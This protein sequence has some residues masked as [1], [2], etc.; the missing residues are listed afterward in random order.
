MFWQ[1]PIKSSKSAVKLVAWP[2]T[3]SDVVLQH[4]KVDTTSPSSGD[5][6]T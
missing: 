3:V 2:N 1:L 4:G 5:N 6:S